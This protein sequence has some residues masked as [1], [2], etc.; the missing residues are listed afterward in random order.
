VSK[1][2]LTNASKVVDAYQSCFASID[3]FKANGMQVAFMLRHG[4]KVN[5]P[6]PKAELSD[7]G[8][9][10]VKAYGDAISHLLVPAIRGRLVFASSTP[11]RNLQTLEGVFG[12]ERASIFTPPSLDLINLGPNGEDHIAA[13]Q[14]ARDRPDL[15]KNANEACQHLE[16]HGIV[17]LGETSEAATLRVRGGIVNMMDRV[18][19][20]GRALGIS[21][22]S[23]TG[24]EAAYIFGV[25]KELEALILARN[26]K[27][28]TFTLLDRVAPE[29]AEDPATDS[30]A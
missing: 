20:D 15:F 22:N 21:I 6:N 27:T 18:C 26:P 4:A 7:I 24:N 16:E 14:L 9:A 11:E 12:I 23:P 10:Q 3:A 2:I 28:D 17:R 13:Q 8:L 30:A 19:R 1:L 5:S 29:F 25:L